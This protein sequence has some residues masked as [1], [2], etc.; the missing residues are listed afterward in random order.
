MMEKNILVFPCGSEIGLEINNSLKFV[1]NINLFGGSSISDHGQ[2]VYKNYID[3]LPHIDEENF[4]GKLNEVVKEYEIDFIFPA[5]DSVVLKL[6]ENQMNLNAE[7]ITSPLKTCQ[8]CRSK[9]KTYDFFKNE[10]FVPVTY[11]NVDDVLNYPVFLKPDVGQGSNGIA[12]ANSLIELEA[13]LNRPEKLVISELLPGKEYTIDC[14]TDTKGSLRFTGMRERIRIKS[15][16]SVNSRSQKIHPQVKEIAEIINEKLELR[17]VWFFQVKEDINGNFKLLEIAPRIAGT[18]S[19]YRNKGVNFALL[20]ILDRLNIE[21]DII[22]NDFSV[23]VDRAFA[24]SFKLD[25]DYNRV[26]LDFDDTVTKGE[27]VN[28]YVMMFIYQ[29]LNKGKE[30]YLITKHIYNISETLGKLKIDENL[31]T[32]VIHITKEDDKHKY[33]ENHESSIFIDDAFSERKSIHDMF[34]IP[35]FDVD[36]IESLIDWRN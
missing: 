21:I 31:F 26:Y 24:N 5:H 15:G 35:V 8:I 17:G 34:G 3:E 13:E 29:C 23:N 22:E 12:R 16:I 30:I 20:S 2:F 27:Q 32:K 10:S 28:P 11:Q 19:V 9:E 36:A 4:I 18:M 25:I 7:V 6:S 33:F 14:F 1:K